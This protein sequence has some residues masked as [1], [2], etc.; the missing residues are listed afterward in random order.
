MPNALIRNPVTNWTGTIS[1]SEFETVESRVAS[2]VNGDDGSAHAPT[3][4]ITITGGA[5]VPLLVLGPVVAS[6]AAGKV[7]ANCTATTGGDPTIQLQDGDWV[8]LE[9]GNPFTT[10]IVANETADGRGVPSYH[11]VTRTDG[12]LQAYGPA[13]DLDDGNG[14]QVARAYVPIRAHD[15]STLTQVTIYF[16][17]GAAHPTVPSTMPQIRVLRQDQSG[18]CVALTSTNAGGDANGYVSLPT[19]TSGAGWYASGASQSFTLQCDQNNAIDVSQ[20]AYFV[21]LVE[22]QGLSGYPWVTVYKAPVVAVVVQEQNEAGNATVDNVPVGPGDRVLII[23]SPG[24]PT[25][26]LGIAIFE[27][28]ATLEYANLPQRQSSSAYSIG[29]VIGWPAEPNYYIRCTKSGSTAS[30]PPTFPTNPFIGITPITDDTVVWLVAGYAEA[31]S[32]PAPDMSQP[33]DWKPGM[34]VRVGS[35]GAVF[36]SVDMQANPL[37]AAWGGPSVFIP[38]YVPPTPLFAVRAATTAA[39]IIWDEIESAFEGIA[40]LRPQ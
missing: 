6:R 31:V 25:D 24:T 15:A 11:W 29:D 10:H 18:N 30:S 12:G 36:G 28:D 39:G 40:D 19:A 7:F 14:S 35:Q 2:A 13:Y 5:L 26:I 32:L 16:R 22:E 20:Y 3:S 37:I 33:S 4:A 17:V 23:E 21:E 34:V 9:E 8:E 27:E 1:P 38:D